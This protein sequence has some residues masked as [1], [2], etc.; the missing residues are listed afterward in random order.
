[1]DGFRYGTVHK[2]VYDGLTRGGSQSSIQ[3]LVY[4]SLIYIIFTFSLHVMTSNNCEKWD[5]VEK[6]NNIKEIQANIITTAVTA[7][8]MIFSISN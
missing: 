6:I 2:D 7:I 4:M 5:D 8:L 3:Y 1:M